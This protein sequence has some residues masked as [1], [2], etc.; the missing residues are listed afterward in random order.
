[1]HYDA[2]LASMES[3][4]GGISERYHPLMDVP[5]RLKDGTL[6][7]AL[8]I[9]S[10]AYVSEEFGHHMSDQPL[11][12]SVRYGYDREA[13]LEDL[14]ADVHPVGHQYELGWHVA[15]IIANDDLDISEQEIG[16]V[17]LASMVHDMGE[18]TH[19]RV[20]THC[21]NVVGD[22]AYGLKTKHD[23][24]VEAGIREYLYRTLLADVTFETIRRIEAIIS[25]KDDSLLHDI[26][27]AAHELQTYETTKHAE[28]ALVAD[29]AWSDATPDMPLQPLAQEESARMSSLLG[30]SRWVLEDHLPSLRSHKQRFKHVAQSMTDDALAA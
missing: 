24:L 30:L 29:S 10:R 26:F 20:K 19:P 13:S 21:G 2:P 6:Y 3:P 16:I 22:I 17:M 9:A 8:S 5:V 23:R 11:R 18:T 27:E 4:L 28:A 15:N 7:S 25:H 1:M 14:G 12:F